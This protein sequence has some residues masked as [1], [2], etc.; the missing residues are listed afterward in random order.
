MTVR[1]HRAQ[2]ARRQTACR[3]TQAGHRHSA[4]RGQFATRLRQGVQRHTAC[5]HIQDA[6]RL[7]QAT[8]HAQAVDAHWP[9][10]GC[11]NGCVVK[12]DRH[13]QRDRHVGHIGQIRHC[14]ACPVRR[15]KPAARGTSNPRHLCQPRDV[16]RAA[17][18]GVN[19]VVGGIGPGERDGR[20]GHRLGR[21]HVFIGKAA[22]GRH[23][24]DIAAQAVVGR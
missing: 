11:T 13:A 16:G 9:R 23:G 20:N 2:T 22:C 19:G 18:R 15:V 24:Q 1:R 3:L 10:L 8:C 14:A 5:T 17:G 12:V 4:G 6:C 7:A 21:A